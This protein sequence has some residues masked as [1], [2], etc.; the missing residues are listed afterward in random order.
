MTSWGRMVESGRPDHM[1]KLWDL[2]AHLYDAVVGLAPYEELLHEVAELVDA[3]PGLRVLDAGCGTGALADRLAERCPDLIYVGVDSSKAMLTRARA[4]RAWPAGFAFVE[5]D[6]DAVL[7]RDVDGFDRVASV[8]VIW[9]LADPGATLAR[10]TLALRPGGHMVHAT[11]RLGFRA[12]VIVWRHLRARRG[13]ALARAVLGLPSLLVGGLLNLLL[14]AQSALR[15]R[16]PGA[17]RRFSEAGLVALL[18]E[19]GA[20]PRL[21]R[22]CYAGQAHLLVAARAVDGSRHPES[23]GRAATGS[24]LPAAR[25]E[26]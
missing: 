20:E 23:G 15:A 4:R 21:V 9:A 19:G 6:L 14:V 16:G 1:P 3:R 17:R 24:R 2:Y 10:M 13:W 8:N 18:R 22:R 7:A 25:D 5:G 12:D 11:P 26:R